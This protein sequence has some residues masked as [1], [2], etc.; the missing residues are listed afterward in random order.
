MPIYLIKWSFHVCL[1][2]MCRHM[3]IWIIVWTKTP[4]CVG[5]RIYTEGVN[6][7]KVAQDDCCLTHC[8]DNVLQCP[9]NFV[10]RP[11]EHSMLP[12]PIQVFRLRP[13]Q[14][15]R[16]FTNKTLAGVW[17]LRLK[18][19]KKGEEPTAQWSGNSKWWMTVKGKGSGLYIFL[20]FF[21]GQKVLMHV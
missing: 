7:I 3:C 18:A 14:H 20:F 9:V 15:S 17:I 10:L 5:L 8:V 19:L 11:W 2:E 21:I 1:W 4:Q 6:I 12:L 16:G 13:M